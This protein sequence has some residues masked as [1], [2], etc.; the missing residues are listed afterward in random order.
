MK[1]V[2]FEIDPSLYTQVKAEVT[3]KYPLLHFYI[4][5]R[6]V[7]V[8]GSFPVIHGDTEIDSYQ[9]EIRLPEQYPQGIP[10]V[11][12][13]GKRIPRIADRHMFVDGRACLFVEEDWYAANP[14]RTDLLEFLDGPV[15]NFFIGQSLVEAG[16]SWPFG[17]RSHGARGI[18]E[19]YAEMIGT[20]DLQTAF[21]YLELLSKKEIKGH[22]L[23]PCG[24][25]RK[26]RNCHYAVIRELKQRIPHRIVRRS[27]EQIWSS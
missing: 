16:R 12:E 3:A 26:L 1:Q 11:W 5:G 8:A 7:I 17:Q 9:I 24:S 2:W 27:W 18:L 15:R 25:R 22:W 21:K 13:I 4:Q 14:Q 19:C 10:Y 23:C 6:V 20:T